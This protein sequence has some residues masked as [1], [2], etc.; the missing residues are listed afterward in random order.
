MNGKSDGNLLAPTY[1][2]YF[3]ETC[4]IGKVDLPIPGHLLMREPKIQ[5]LRPFI[6]RVSH[7]FHLF[8]P[9]E[10]RPFRLPPLIPRNVIVLD[11]PQKS[12]IPTANP[13][14]DLVTPLIE[15][16]V[17]FTI[18]VRSHYIA[19]L[20]KHV[21]ESSGDCASADRIGV[22]AVPAYENRMAVRV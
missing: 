16:L 6:L 4:C 17:V 19:S 8:L 15:R 14:Q 18:D 5:S 1:T 21:V 12:N 2:L 9:I 22:A 10:L 11:E 13:Q 7:I 20:D 3:L